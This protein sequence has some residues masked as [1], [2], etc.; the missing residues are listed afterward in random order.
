MA[1]L[2]DAETNWKE[3]YEELDRAIADEICRI[4]DG[5][6]AHYSIEEIQFTLRKLNCDYNNLYKKDYERWS[7]SNRL[8]GAREEG[9]V[10]SGLTEAEKI[11]ADLAKLPIWYD[12]FAA[13]PTCRYCNTIQEQ[14]PEEHHAS[15]CVFWRSEEYMKEKRVRDD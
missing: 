11:V 14:A 15:W 7:A 4:R 1:E 6:R 9:S 3:K 5:D 10:P 12:A 8:D 2:T 13:Y